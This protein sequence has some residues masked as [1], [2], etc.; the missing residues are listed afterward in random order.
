MLL[1]ILAPVLGSFMV[2]RISPFAPSS[3]AFFRWELIIPLSDVMSLSPFEFS[4]ATS[5]Y[6][7]LTLLVSVNTCTPSGQIGASLSDGFNR[8]ALVETHAARLRTAN[9]ILVDM[10]PSRRVRRARTGPDWTQERGSENDQ[11]R[12]ERPRAIGRFSRQRRAGMPKLYRP[13]PRPGTRLAAVVLT[14]ALHR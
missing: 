14:H 2:P 10:T 8:A 1:A 9:V 13:R 6:G 12:G 5:V 11:P 4:T 7:L 3:A